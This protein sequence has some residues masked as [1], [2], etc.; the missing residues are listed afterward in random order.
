VVLEIHDCTDHADGSFDSFSL[1]G[2][3]GGS[4]IDGTTITFITEGTPEVM[5]RAARYGGL[6]PPHRQGRVMAVARLLRDQGFQVV[7]ENTMGWPLNYNAYATRRTA[8]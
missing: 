4:D 5:Q 8:A 7:I 6:L 3:R 1:E 2:E